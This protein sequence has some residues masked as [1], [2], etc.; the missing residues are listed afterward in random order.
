MDDAVCVYYNQSQPPTST[1]VLVIYLFIS[2][3]KNQKIVG[4]TSRWRPVAAAAAVLFQKVSRCCR[5][6]ICIMTISW[7]QVPELLRENKIKDNETAWQ[8][9]I[10]KE[11]EEKRAQLI[12]FLPF[13]FP[14]KERKGVYDNSIF[15]MIVISP[16]MESRKRRK[17]R[18]LFKA[19]KYTEEEEEEEEEEE[20]GLSCQITL[21]TPWLM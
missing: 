12:C 13:F 14:Q 17:K 6:D 7:K 3:L 5:N 8:E 21:C 1:Y 10:I 11:E 19:L 2:Q 15:I 9:E 20:T 18:R 4:G 16:Q